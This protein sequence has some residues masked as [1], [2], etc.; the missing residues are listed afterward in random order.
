VI[1]QDEIERERYLSRLK[2]QRDDAFFTEAVREESLDKGEVIGSI[3]MA[4]RVLG[5]EAEPTE[6][7]RAR[8]IE[9]L[10]LIFAQLDDEITKLKGS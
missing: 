5:R 1:T 2:K 8:S 3:R 9:E 6:S 4:Q 10:S 7:L